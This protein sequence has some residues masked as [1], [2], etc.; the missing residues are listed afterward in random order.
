MGQI[1]NDSILQQDL[2]EVD[3]LIMIDADAENILL[4]IISI[5]LLDLYLVVSC[6][7]FQLNNH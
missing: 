1:E 7:Q 3:L 2:Y 4:L 5:S 6:I